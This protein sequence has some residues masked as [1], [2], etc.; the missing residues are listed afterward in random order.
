[1]DLTLPTSQD[2]WCSPVKSPLINTMIFKLD[3]IQISHGGPHE[4]DKDWVALVE[5]EF[6]WVG[7]LYRLHNMKSAPVSCV[8]QWL[9]WVPG[10]PCILAILLHPILRTFQGVPQSSTSGY[11]SFLS[12]D[13]SASFSPSSGFS[14]LIV[15]GETT[16]VFLSVSHDLMWPDWQ[17]KALGMGSSE[18]MRGSTLKLLRGLLKRGI[19][20]TGPVRKFG[21]ARSCWQPSC[22]RMKSTR[23]KTEL[24]ESLNLRDIFRAFGPNYAWKSEARNSLLF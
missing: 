9:T 14:T 1:M 3:C 22:L 12:F 16:L 7:C 6:G 4:T 13:C 15:F 11:L 18:T 19:V 20:S 5:M 23:S 21:V 2:P 10:F 24:R 17:P 8:I